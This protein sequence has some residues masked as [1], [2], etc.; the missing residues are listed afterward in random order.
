M[1]NSCFDQFQP[2]AAIATTPQAAKTIQPLAQSINATLYLPKSLNWTQKAHIYH[3]FTRKQLNSIWDQ[4]SAFIFC[5]ATGAVVRLIAPLLKDKSCDPAVVVID[6]EGR[7]VISLC[8]GH[9]GGAD[10]LTQLIAQQIGATPIITG[11]SSSL[12]LPAMDILGIPY[13]WRKGEGDWTRVMSAIASGENIQ[14][15]Q[16]V[17]STLWQRHLP[18]KHAFYFGFSESQKPKACIWI[19]PTKRKF[20]SDSN[21]PNVQWH[22]RILWV[23]IGCERGTSKQLIEAAI[24]TTLQKYHL[25]TEAI[26]GISTINIKADEQGILELCDS[27]NLPLKT[28]SAELLKQVEVPTP[29]DV[30]NQEVGTPSVAEAAAILATKNSSFTNTLLLP[31]QIFKRDNE[32]GPIPTKYSLPVRPVYS[33]CD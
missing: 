4:Y 5:L 8:S 24:T 33:I 25:A 26:A 10:K 23:G 6:A 12:N 32:P 22:P 2:I 30:V 11:A 1:N 13:G 17:G 21:L 9:Q 7:F 3:E 16:E 27:W 20:A 18:D 14:V 31:K 19:S 15:I 29:S 28:F